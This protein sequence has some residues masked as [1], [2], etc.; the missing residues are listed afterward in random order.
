MK[1]E[2]KG[3]IGLYPQMGASHKEALKLATI[4]FSIVTK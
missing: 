2:R 1:E 4:V 3:W